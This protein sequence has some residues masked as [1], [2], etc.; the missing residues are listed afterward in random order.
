M[1]MWGDSW[2]MMPRPAATSDASRLGWTS[3]RRQ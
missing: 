2:F 3:W 1:M